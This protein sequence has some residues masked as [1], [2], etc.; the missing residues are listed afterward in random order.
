MFKRKLLFLFSLLS[1]VLLLHDV[2]KAVF[3]VNQNGG[4]SGRYG[5]TPPCHPLPQ[6][7][8]WLDPFILF[9]IFKFKFKFKFIDFEKSKFKFKFIDFD[10]TK[11][12]FIDF[13]IVE[14]KF[15][16]NS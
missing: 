3:L 14:F 7:R 10:K 4:T 11:F 1:V 16:I 2:T 5:G 9:L 12:K 15:I 6:R 8:H 13:A